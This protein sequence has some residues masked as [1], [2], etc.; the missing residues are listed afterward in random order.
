MCVCETGSAV[1]AYFYFDF[2]DFAKQTCHDLLRSLV[3]Q[4][5]TRSSPA[6]TRDTKV[7]LDSPAM[8]A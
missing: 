1:V 7:T 3:F 6:F 8:T 2:K 4:L 5:S